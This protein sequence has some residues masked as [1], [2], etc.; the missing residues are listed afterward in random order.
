M[1]REAGLSQTAVS[2]IWRAFGLQPHRQ[3]TFKLS[4][5]PLFVEKVRDIVGLY[6]DP[7][8]KAMVLCVD[9]KSQIQALD[10]TQPLLPLAPGIPERRTHD[11]VRHGTTTLFAALDIATG[12]V[13]GELH[14]R[15][16]SS[17][18]LQFLRTIE[19]NVPPRAGRP[20]RDGQLRHAQDARDQDLVCPPSALPRALHADLGV[21]AQS[22]RALV[23]H[24]DRR[25]TSAAARI[26][27][28]ANSSRPSGTTSTSTTPTPS[29]SSGPRP[30][31]TSSPASRDFVCELL[32]H[33]T[34]CPHRVCAVKRRRFP[35]TGTSGSCD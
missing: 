18:F 7:P 14:R 4:S 19:A 16:R 1:A 10:R 33:D 12:E 27:R 6:L 22:G 24:A 35:S 31:T 29:R 23:R 15:H 13:I 5:D 3:E 2:R 32:T 8:L 9:E 11:Y 26:A 28:R 30:P 21:L 25:S 20:S 17:E 34:R